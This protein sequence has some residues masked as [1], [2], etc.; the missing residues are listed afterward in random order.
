MFFWGVSKIIHALIL[1]MSTC[2]MECEPYIH[3]SL[4]EIVQ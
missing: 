4:C 2:Q 1:H 3:F